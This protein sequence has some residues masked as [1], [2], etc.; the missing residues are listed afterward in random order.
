MAAA[1]YLNTVQKIYIAFY[2]RP[3]D[4]EGLAYWAGRL[5]AVN[6]NLAGIINA[7]ATSDEAQSLYGPI[8]ANT[9][10][11]VIDSIYLASKT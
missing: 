10:G 6:G 8:N 11:T 4:P 1:D 5:N 3:A 2:Q 7:F 9:I